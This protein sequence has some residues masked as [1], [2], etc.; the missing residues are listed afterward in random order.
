[1]GR[2]YALVSSR[3]RWGSEWVIGAAAFSAGHRCSSRWV[4]WRRVPRRRLPRG[5]PAARSPWR[6]ARADRVRVFR[7]RWPSTRAP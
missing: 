7:I 6:T 5:R 3:P 2:W 4:F 1:M